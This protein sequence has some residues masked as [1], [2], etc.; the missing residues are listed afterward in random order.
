MKYIEAQVLASS[1][2]LPGAI[3][4]TEIREKL[5]C[6]CS[7]VVKRQRPLLQQVIPSDMHSL[8]S[9]KHRVLLFNILW[10]FVHC[11]RLFRHQECTD[12]TSIKLNLLLFRPDSSGNHSFHSSQDRFPLSAT[13]QAHVVPFTTALVS[14]AAL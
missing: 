12:S 14:G 1:M 8:A 13:H 10:Y 4:L 3:F 9:G 7:P 2:S 11:S 6:M 5:M